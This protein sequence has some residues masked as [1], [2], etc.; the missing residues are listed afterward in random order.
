MRRN[1]TLSGVL[2]ALIL[3][4]S[5]TVPTGLPAQTRGEY[6][7]NTDPGI[8][9][10]NKLQ[11]ESTDSNGYGIYSLDASTLQSGVNILGIRAL[12]GNR[13][14]HTQ[15]HFVMV[16]VEPQAERPQT[17]EYFWDTDPGLG[18][19]SSLAISANQG[20]GP[21]ELSIPADTLPPGEHRLGLR[22]CSGGA[23]SQT[24]M[25]SVMVSDGRITAVI[26]AE[27]FWGAD[28]GFGKGTPIELTP[29]E[30]I[31]IDELTIDFP[32]ETAEEYALSFRARSEQGWGTTQTTVLP[33][34]YVENIN[35]SAPTDSVYVSSR[36]PLH[37]EIVP[38]DA[39]VDLLEWSSSAPAVAS[40]DADGVVEGVSEGEA[41]IRADATDGTGV[42]AEYPVK[43]TID[44]QSGIRS[45]TVLSV[46]VTAGQS[47]IIISGAP[48][49]TLVEVTSAGGTTVYRG[50]EQ[51]IPIGVA[52]IYLV[53]VNGITYKIVI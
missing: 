53:K 41:I 11:P 29:G 12:D 4:I 18:K 49:G 39:F 38:A 26:A 8:G 47:E 2:T 19:A 25:A 1:S 5:T 9:K 32:Q 35:L 46:T 50:T 20:N 52:G 42:Y 48:A 7:W 16:P 24:L 44:P 23:W 6:Y 37:A 27:Y 10:G 15:Y 45:L 30:E 28:P 17:V 14:S 33:H 21:L 36:L 43:V 51:R 34:L 40:V 31:A 22:S 13:W 3:C